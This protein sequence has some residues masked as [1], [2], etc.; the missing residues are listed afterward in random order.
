MRTAIEDDHGAKASRT[1]SLLGD[2][3][4]VD[5]ACMRAWNQV[6]YAGIEV[7]DVFGVS[8]LS[9]LVPI[10]YVG[11]VLRDASVYPTARGRNSLNT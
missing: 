11:T 10:T 7:K 2:R 5:I 4:C 8:G 1:L 3:C 6:S 9:S